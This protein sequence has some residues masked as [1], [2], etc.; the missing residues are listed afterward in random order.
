MIIFFLQLEIYRPAG[1]QHRNTRDC[2]TPLGQKLACPV[3]FE[4]FV[5]GYGGGHTKDEPQ[6]R[7]EVENGVWS[8]TRV[9]GPSTL[10]AALILSLSLYIFFNWLSAP[11]VSLIGSSCVH[12]F[13]IHV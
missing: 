2:S 5:I 3:E 6:C 10:L 13:I 8:C 4:D 1:P 12:V 11:L 7:R 9:H